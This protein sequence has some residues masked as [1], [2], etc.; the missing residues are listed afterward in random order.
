[1]GR[2][3]SL[4]DANPSVIIN[5]VR[6]H[7]GKDPEDGGYIVENAFIAKDYWWFKTK[8]D[9]LAFMVTLPESASR[10]RGYEPPTGPMTPEQ[11][12]AHLEAYFE[13]KRARLRETAAERVKAGTA[14]Q[15][16]MDLEGRNGPHI[17]QRIAAAGRSPEG[18]HWLVCLWCAARLPYYG[19]HIFMQNNI[20]IP[21]IWDQKVPT[22]GARPR[23]V[24][25]E[26]LGAQQETTFA[27]VVGA[28]KNREYA[29]HRAEQ[30][31]RGA[32]PVQ[33]PFAEWERGPEQAV[34]EPA[35]MRKRTRDRG[36]HER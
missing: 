9:F 13:G 34:D 36:G 11:H 33:S 18:R 35:R 15:F 16:D 1:M 3:K 5:R 7:Y 30:Y 27:V 12:A 29:L 26:F 21:L 10:E 32:V 23:Y 8:E 31:E 17:P 28:T 6:Y 14:Q 2:D 24:M 20:A 19:D 4:S 25:A 22:P